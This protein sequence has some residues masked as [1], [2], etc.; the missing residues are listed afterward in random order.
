MDIT[1]SDPKEIAKFD[2]LAAEWW[3]PKG[4]FSTL[5][6]INPTRLAYLQQ[7][8]NLHN[9]QILDV[10]CGAGLLAESMAKNG[11]SV[12]GIDLAEEAIKAANI[13][14]QHVDY[15]I[16]YQNISVESLA[17]SQPNTF[18]VITCMEMLEHVPDPSSVIQACATL[19]T[20]GAD[21]FFSTLNRNLKTYLSAIVA[22]EYVLKIIPRNTHDYRKFIR[23]AELDAWIREAGL[24]PVDIV[25]L[26]YQPLTRKSS[27]NKDVSI[28]Y[29]I[30]AKK[31]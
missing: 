12:T 10:G 19:A 26:Q 20:T 21:L 16:K 29:I 30:H 23:P 22:A 11:G 28:N 1:N 17:E 31:P 6:D 4:P 15:N 14:Q 2:Q 24:I 25:G 7:R 13:H 27:I 5:H 18:E 8:T 3:D 9:K